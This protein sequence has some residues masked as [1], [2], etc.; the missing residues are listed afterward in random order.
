MSDGRFGW[1]DGVYGEPREAGVPFDWDPYEIRIPAHWRSGVYVAILVEGS[2]RDRP[3]TLPDR[4]TP[5]ARTAK[6]LFVVRG[7]PARAGRAD[8]L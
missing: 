5:D 3:T 2:R 8:P 4:S 6:A 1:F 7:D